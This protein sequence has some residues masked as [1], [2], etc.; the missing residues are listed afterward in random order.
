MSVIMP[1]C[2]FEPFT[3]EV[4]VRAGQTRSFDVRLVETLNGQTLGDDPA[5]NAEMIRR[6]S[7]VPVRPVPR[8]A[9]GRP[10]LSGV[11]L[12]NPDPSPEPPDALP[13]AD[14]VAKE[15][16]ENNFKDHP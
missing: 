9:N 7:K 13:W 11:W 3:S 10:D 12:I 15:W 1:C 4:T 6:R 2:T 14:A 5:R 8:L 16:R